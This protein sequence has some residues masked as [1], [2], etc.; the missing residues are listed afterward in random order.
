MSP[1]NAASFCLPCRDVATMAFST[2]STCLI[3]G[4]FSRE[5]VRLLHCSV[6]RL[7]WTST[8]SWLTYHNLQSQS[9][10]AWAMVPKIDLFRHCLLDF[11]VMLADP[12]TEY[13]ISPLCFS[14]EIGEDLIGRTCRLADLLQLLT[15]GVQ[16][17]V[18]E[19]YLIKARL[20][21]RRAYPK[22]CGL[23]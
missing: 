13:I 1:V 22:L 23:S 16:P 14:C 18:L 12:T 15:Q 5:L 3:T 8:A 6:A 10:A 20:L 7:S 21:W 17:C 2:T 11:E 19:L 9:F 4:C